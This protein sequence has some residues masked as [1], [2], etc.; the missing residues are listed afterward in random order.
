MPNGNYY[1]R[2]RGDLILKQACVEVIDFS[3]V[4]EIVEAMCRYVAA[5]DYGAGL[6]APQMGVSKRIVVLE[7]NGKVKEFIN[8][9][10]T[11]SSNFRV[12]LPE[13]C[14]SL[15]WRDIR[16]KWRSL[17]IDV[18]YQDR[19]G[20]SHSDR[21]VGFPSLALQHEIDHLDGK[22]ITY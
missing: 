3:E 1:L 20:V 22:L 15:R 8:P 2:K 5:N 16:L 12:P 14:L 9:A 18:V 17:A 13:H 21:Y 7:I 4:G 19:E 10:I 11:A 6:A